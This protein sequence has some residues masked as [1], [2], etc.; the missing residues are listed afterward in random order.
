MSH[1]VLFLAAAGGVAAVVVATHQGHPTP[2]ASIVW[3]GSGAP[4][5]APGIAA[6]PQASP[7]PT[8][9]PAVSPR[10]VTGPLSGLFG[11]LNTDTRRGAAGEYSILQQIGGT[12]RE[13]F[14][15]LLDSITRS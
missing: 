11:E 13:W 7:V 15:H 3:P 5:A 1:R 9:T 4:S 14:V 10:G 12:L 6:Q 8:A 2:G